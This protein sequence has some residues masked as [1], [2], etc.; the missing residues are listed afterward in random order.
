MQ[1][2]LSI[3][4]EKR[5]KAAKAVIFD[6]GEVLCH[7]PTAEEIARRG[8]PAP[9]LHGQGEPAAAGERQFMCSMEERR[10]ES[11]AKRLPAFKIIQENLCTLDI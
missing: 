6:Y 7:R 4:R 2:Y 8:R 10:R 3:H 1:E 5:S 9:S 11:N